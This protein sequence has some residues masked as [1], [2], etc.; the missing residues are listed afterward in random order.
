MPSRKLATYRAMRDFSQTREPSG[1]DKVSA[2]PHLRFV[3]QKHA[4][5]RLHYDFRL[6]LER[7]LPILGGDARALARSRPTSG[8]RWRWKTI[9]WIMAISKAPFPRASMAAAR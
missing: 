1:A 9:R 7:H 6:E 2:A 3:I 4:A 8:W 5:T